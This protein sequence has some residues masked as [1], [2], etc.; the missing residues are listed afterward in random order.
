M[1]NITITLTT[2]Q[3]DFI[4]NALLF[5]ADS[6]L[7]AIDD[8]YGEPM[9]TEESAKTLVDNVLTNANQ[10][11]ESLKA[12]ITE[13]ERLLAKPTKKAAPYGYKAD[14]TPKKKPG[15]PSTKGK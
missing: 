7:D 14:G 1:N 15:R 2:A 6:V 3:R 8:E 9:T 5:T 10:E 11:I 13:Q 4:V 12:K